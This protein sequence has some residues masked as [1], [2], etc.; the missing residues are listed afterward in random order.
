MKKLS[1]Y[2]QDVVDA[3]RKCCQSIIGTKLNNLEGEFKRTEQRQFIRRIIEFIEIE[4]GFVANAGKLKDFAREIENKWYA[5]YDALRKV[6]RRVY[7][8]FD[9]SA[10]AKRKGTRLRGGGLPLI[11]AALTHLRYCPYCNADMIFTIRIDKSGKNVKSAF[12]H[13]FP[14]RRYPFLGLS[15]YNLIPACTRCNSK[16]KLAKYKETLETFYPHLDD[17]DDAT[18]F[19]LIGL[20]NEMRHGKPSGNKLKVHLLLKPPPSAAEQVRL[21]N[22]QALFRIDDVYSQLYNDQALRILQLGTI[23]N[24]TYRD[25][26][27]QRFA[28][29]DLHVNLTSLLLDT[30]LKRSEID[31]HHLSKLK[32]DILEQYWDIQIEK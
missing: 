2:P 10:F 4:D 23:L 5:N 7:E 14:R 17:L 3:H 15:L 29:A 1:P 9:Y 19:V 12:D 22:Y 13:F 20:T 21:E 11:K 8:I 28:L 31:R 32:L 30:P 25:E 18:Q 16:F 6:N 24:K 27:A 26:I